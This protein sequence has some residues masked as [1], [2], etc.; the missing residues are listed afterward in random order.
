MKPRFL[1]RRDFRRELVAAVLMLTVAG[2]TVKSGEAVVLSKEHIA[3]TPATSEQAAQPDRWIVQVEMIS[4]LRKVNV[5][6]AAARW[7]ALKVG[8]RLK[9]SYSQ[10]KYT[11]TIWGS[12]LK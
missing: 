3:G 8:D 7:D 4:D 11:G 2:C 9:V 1:M 12:E 6:V 5:E 10:G